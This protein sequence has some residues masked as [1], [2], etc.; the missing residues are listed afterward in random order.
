MSILRLCIALLEQFSKGRSPTLR[1]VSRADRVGHDLLFD[2][3][4][5]DPVIQVKILHAQNQLAD[6]LTKGSLLVTDGDRLL[7]LFIICLLPQS[8]KDLSCAN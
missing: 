8:F 6:I 2:R 5:L 7:R 3:I 4:N 1:H